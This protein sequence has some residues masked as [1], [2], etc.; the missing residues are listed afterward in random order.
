MGF[1]AL[2][3]LLPVAVRF[4]SKRRKPAISWTL[5]GVAFGALISLLAWDSTQHTSSGPSS[6]SQACWAFSRL[7]FTVHRVAICAYGA[8]SSRLGW[9]LALGIWLLR[10]STGSSGERSME[11]SAL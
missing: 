10:P 1:L 8:A 4:W 6:S 5:T 7:F 11:A 3:L 2:L 9:Y